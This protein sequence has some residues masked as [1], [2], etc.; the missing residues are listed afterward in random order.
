M[1][2]AENPQILGDRGKSLEDEF[3]RNED[4]RAIERLRELKERTS[5]REALARG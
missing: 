3:F 4:K 1:G 2:M 5:S